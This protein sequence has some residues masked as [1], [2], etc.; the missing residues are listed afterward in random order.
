MEGST[1]TPREDL[2]NGDELKRNGG[3]LPQSQPVNH[4]KSNGE[5]ASIKEESNISNTNTNTNTNT[6]GTTPAGTA[7]DS[8]SR[9]STTHSNFG[10]HTL[11]TTAG[12]FPNVGSTLGSF[13]CLGRL[14]KGTFCSIHRC[15]DMSYFHT[16]KSVSNGKHG[17]NI[18]NNN[19]SGRRR[20]GA[21]K[22][23]VSDFKNSGVLTGEATMLN[24]L[25]S[26][27]P[28]NT[29]PK[30]M[31]Y[32]VAGD[33]SAIVMEFLPGQDMHQIRDLSLR[34]KGG[35]RL[36][37]ADSVRLTAHVMLPLLKAMHDVG[38]VH[39]DVKPSNCVKR[40]LKD[41]LMVDFG[42]SKSIVVPKDSPLSDPDSPFDGDK[43]IRPAGYDGPGHYRKERAKA[44]FRGTSMY[45]SPRVH[46]LKDY[47]ARD[48]IWS[49]M[50]V[51]CD[52]VSGGLPWMSFAANRERDA[53]QQLKERIHGLDSEGALDLTAELLK[54]NEY[55]QALFKRNKG[56]ID[57]NGDLN[58]EIS[59]PEPLN[60]SKHPK[61]VECL[62]NV[63][64]HLARL[65][66]NEKP[67]YAL[68]RRYLEDFAEEAKSLESTV[69]PID[70][71][72]VDTT[73]RKVRDVAPVLGEM[74]PSWDFED[75]EDPIEADIFVRAESETSDEVENPVV[76]EEAELQSLP[77]EFR[78]RLAQMQ[79][80][81]SKPTEVPLHIALRDWMKVAL[82]LLYGEWDTAMYEKGGHRK[83]GDRFRRELYLKLIVKCINC[84]E[85]FKNFRE[86]ECIYEDTK[87]GQPKKRRKIHCT[88]PEPPLNS[89][90]SELIAIS[91]VMYRLRLAMKDEDAKDRAPPPA[92]SFGGR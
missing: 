16:D 2:D 60:L 1:S 28:E 88:V 54:G 63:F 41:F 21:A 23:E 18:Q 19:N 57:P 59:V 17:N 9:T 43:W 56:K 6:I 69:D 34:H 90:G 91:Q 74:V 27:T 25:D 70:W 38:I 3:A 20:L 83:T 80:N 65:G 32:Y 82:P 26:S 50:Y 24:F 78:F 71:D 36:S 89:T 77:L 10:S 30:Y 64:D 39:R 92:L 76:G 14:G 86:S 35:R 45:A 48:D 8:K 37:V 49:L 62:N 7:T 44:D 46:Q 22:V 29:V 81:M 66:F 67:D 47:C 12:G 85:R 58:E 15:I 40:G 52:L 42:L 4:N 51:F 13:F 53:C 79:Y 11:V 55:H 75:I 31:G 5:T 68:V 73:K 33:I 72:K 87:E 61:L 84:S